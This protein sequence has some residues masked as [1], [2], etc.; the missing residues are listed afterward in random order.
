MFDVTKI[1]KDFPIF[2]S[3]PDLVYLDSSS[4]TQTPQVVLDAMQKYY[5]EYR[6]NTRRGQYALS[7]EA[8]ETYENARKEVA[9]FIN[10]SPDEIIFT[11]SATV[12]MNMLLAS[13][14]NS[15]Y[16]NAG[17]EIMTTVMEH[18]SL[19]IPLQQLAKRKNLVVKYVGMD[20]NFELDYN[21]AEKLINE[22]TKLVAFANVSNVTG[23]VH[24][25]ERLFNLL[26]CQGEVPEGRRGYVEADPLWAPPISPLAGG[27]ENRPLSI[28]DA[29][30]AVGHIPVDVKKLDCDFLFFSGHKMLG[31]TGIGVL[32]GKKE[33]LEK[34]EPGFFGGGMVDDIVLDSARWTE[35]PWK[36]EAGTPNIAGAIGLCAAFEYLKEIGVESIEA[37]IRELTGYALEK[38]SSISGVKLYCEKDANKNA[39]IISFA[40]EGK[41][42]AHPH[43]VAEILSRYN[44]A[45]RA[46]HH[47]AL[48][49]VKAMKVPAL[50]RASIYL[51]N[52]KEDIDALVRGVEKAKEVLTK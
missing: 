9:E 30:Q 36:F 28:I 25:T 45:V 31:P 52:A 22:K 44:I 11:S 49:L 50:T 10:A 39:G 46:G 19:L 21:Q 47:C 51:Y 3:H 38:L 26:P 33:L 12:S 24:D 35:S 14:E 6:A 42:D 41:H 48:P 7:V 17:D 13:L 43:D 18:H 40:I 16:L 15:G 27:E 34:L 4:T 8:D 1:K 23:T 37:R 2:A 5:T 29:T 20:E 32:Y